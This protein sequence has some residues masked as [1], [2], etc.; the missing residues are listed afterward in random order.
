MAENGEKGYN[1]A[2]KG[3]IDMILLDLIMPGWSGLETLHK[4]KSDPLTCSI[5]VTIN[6]SK[7]ITDEERRILE[8]DTIDI[9]SKSSDI[10][11][12]CSPVSG[13]SHEV[14]VKNIRV[15]RSAGAVNGRINYGSS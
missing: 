4:L 6:T 8:K 1:I 3:G 12:S 5:P 2:R 14:R 15:W 10:G 7:E 13:M 9:I 11:R